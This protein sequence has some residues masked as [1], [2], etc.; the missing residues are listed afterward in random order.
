MCKHT[1]KVRRETASDGGIPL[2]DS[3]LCRA[4]NISVAIISVIRRLIVP[5][6]S[7]IH[8]R[9]HS[10]RSLFY[11]YLI[12]A[13]DKTLTAA[14]RKVP[15]FLPHSLPPSSSS[16]FSRGWARG[17]KDQHKRS[18]Q[19]DNSTVI[20]R[21]FVPIRLATVL[22]TIAC[23]CLRKT[24]ARNTYREALPEVARATHAFTFVI[25]S[26][27]L[28]KGRSIARDSIDVEF[29]YFFSTQTFT[30]FIYF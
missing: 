23:D 11:P 22:L 6:R 3:D 18:N 25:I 26:A 30:K 12:W 5:D 15:P 17:S 19:S 29:F 28:V 21:N 13:M 9:A 1:Q 10:A 14:P 7:S 27:L 8:E 4:G 24:I 2:G 20:A 16:S